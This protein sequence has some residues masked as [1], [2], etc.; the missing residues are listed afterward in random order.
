MRLANI[1]RAGYG[2]TVRH[3]VRTGLV[4]GDSAFSTVRRISIALEFLERAA[5][6]TIGLASAL[7]R[8]LDGRNPLFGYSHVVILIPMEQFASV[9]LSVRGRWTRTCLS[10]SRVEL[11]KRRLTDLSREVQ[12][13]RKVALGRTTPVHPLPVFVQAVQVTV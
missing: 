11:L 8:K 2:N 10:K 4:V 5:R 13:E 9:N 3:T 6:E 12:L 7:C 1:L